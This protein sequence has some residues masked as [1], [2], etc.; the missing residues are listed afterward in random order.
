MLL[1]EKSLKVVIQQ[2]RSWYALGLKFR[3][4]FRN[5]ATWA[6]GDCQITSSETDLGTEFE[7][8]PAT[9]NEEAVAT[10]NS[11]TTWLKE[12]KWLATETPQPGKG[13]Q[14]WEIIPDH[15]WDREALFMW[16][17]DRSGR[18]IGT[19][20]SVAAKTVYNRMTQLR[21]LHGK[22]LVPERRKSG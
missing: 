13:S 7:E 2:R 6:L 20:V 1:P 14:P 16:W 22:G 12:K 19:K 21:K 4:E 18:D 3:G 17:A 5:T 10:W 9:A 11:F 8:L 15:N